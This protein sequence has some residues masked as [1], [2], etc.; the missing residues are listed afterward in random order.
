MSEFRTQPI[1][2][3]SFLLLFLKIYF[4]LS[5][6]CCF[7]LFIPY[8]RVDIAVYLAFLCLN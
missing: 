8:K 1:P 3:I 7:S 6:S 5:S 2:Q 4:S